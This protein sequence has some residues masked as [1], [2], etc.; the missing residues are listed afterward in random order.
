MHYEK[1]PPIVKCCN[2][3]KLIKSGIPIY[4][5]ILECLFQSKMALFGS[6]GFLSCPR[7]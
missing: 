4:F 5:N 7:V 6:T 3:C 1:I 2:S